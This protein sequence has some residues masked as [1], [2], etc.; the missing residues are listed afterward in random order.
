MAERPGINLSFGTS[1]LIAAEEMVWGTS[2]ILDLLWSTPISLVCAIP[3]KESLRMIT[4]LFG[5]CLAVHFVVI[6][7]NSGNCKCRDRQCIKCKWYFLFRNQADGRWNC[8]FRFWIFTFIKRKKKQINNS[9]KINC[10]LYL[11]KAAMANMK[12]SAI[13]LQNISVYATS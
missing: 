8:H 12:P 7:S 11:K 2:S 3:L 4:D 10:M 9:E 6:F 13:F 5:Y 1:K